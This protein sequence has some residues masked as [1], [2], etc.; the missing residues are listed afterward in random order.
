MGAFAN[1][2]PARTSRVNLS[3]KQPWESFAGHVAGL[4]CQGQSLKF[5]Y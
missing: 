2:S 5:D 3:L 1:A 4:L